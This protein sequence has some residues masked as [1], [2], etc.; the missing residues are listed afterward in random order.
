[1]NDIIEEQKLRR[2]LFHVIWAFYERSH[3]VG[4]GVLQAVPD[5]I[6]RERLEAYIQKLTMGSCLE[7]DLDYAFGKMMKTTFSI[8]KDGT[9]KVDHSSN[10]EY[11]SWLIRKMTPSERRKY[12]ISEGLNAAIDD[13]EIGEETLITIINRNTR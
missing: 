13:L 10:P 11:C 6:A 9:I 3:V 7:L 1:M 2:V 4:M 12:I 5:P 8:Y